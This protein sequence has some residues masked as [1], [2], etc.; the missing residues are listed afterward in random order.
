MIR[1]IKFV[2]K[3]LFKIER[4]VHFYPFSQP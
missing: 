3:F 2:F 1:N 4:D